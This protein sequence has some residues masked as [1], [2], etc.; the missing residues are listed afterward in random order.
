MPGSLK[1]VSAIARPT[2]AELMD[3]ARALLPAIAARVTETNE[4]RDLS[5]EIV[6]E[7]RDAELFRSL[8]PQAWGGLELDP[9]VVLDIQNVFAEVCASTAWIYGVLSVQ[10]F[11]LARFSPQAQMDVWGEDPYAL[12][13]SSFQPVSKVTPV[14]GGFLLSGRHTFSSGSSH[15]DWALL[16]G[17]VPPGEGREAPQMRLFLVPRSDYEIVDVWHV[18]GLR[19]T[20]SNDIVVDEVFVPTHRT[21]CPDPGML[22][23]PASSELPALYRLPWMHMFTSMVSNLGV[24]TARG[25]LNYFTETTRTRVAGFG[26]APSRENP[27]FLSAIGRVQ[28]ELDALDLVAKRNF[29]R[30]LECVDADEEMTM[31]EVLLYRSQLTSSM[32][33]ISAL[34]DEL[35]L[36][37]GGRGI[38][39][40]SPLT[41]AWLDLHAARSHMGNDPTATLG[42]LA[43]E[44]LAGR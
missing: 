18:I 39:T 31:S 2:N 1:A 32:R 26:N 30:L 9:R 42:Q 38:R 35:M 5:P 44:V 16:G 11:F 13:S 20:G 37:L 33:R 34:V 24:G 21:Y 4:R 29:G 25:A 43:G 28:M 6:A 23:L 41:Q 7:I 3:R 10:A 36:L 17:I 8:Q 22:P 40:D 12:V 14:E 27:V 15:C 19:G